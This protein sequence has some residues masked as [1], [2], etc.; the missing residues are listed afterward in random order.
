M[1]IKYLLA[2]GSL[3]MQDD[4][5]S[6]RSVLLNTYTNRRA[7]AVDLAVENENTR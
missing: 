4:S 1:D 7:S 2:R 3:R 5:S 6:M